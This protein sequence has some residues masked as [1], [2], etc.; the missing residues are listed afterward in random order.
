MAG[1]TIRPIVVS[2]SKGKAVQDLSELIRLAGYKFVKVKKVIIKPNV[3][4][5]FPPDIRLLERVIEA[6]QPLTESIVI[7]ETNSTMH[8]PENRFQQLGITALA[9]R[10]GIEAKNLLKEPII[11][12]KVPSPHAMKE[13]P[14][15]SSL[16]EADVLVNVP[17]LGMHSLTLFTCALKNLFGLVAVRSKYAELHPLGVDK[18]IADVYQVIKPDLNIVDAGERV[19]VGIDALGV[20]VVA[21]EFKGIDPLKVEH[22][23]L[24]GK[25]LGI[26]LEKLKVKRIT[27]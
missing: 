16:F 2:S 9:K 7:G 24:V 13:I 6:F 26:G 3:C 18:V 19:L 17:G 20:D 5:M 8:S 21:T 25:D 14:F 23:V 11:K 1:K 4:G 10:Y 22:L 12:K 27:L 15:P